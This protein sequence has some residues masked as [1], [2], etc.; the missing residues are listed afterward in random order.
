MELLFL[1][2]ITKFVS[3]IAPNLVNNS[4]TKIVPKIDPNLVNNSYIIL[5]NLTNQ[6]H[7]V[8]YKLPDLDC[9]ISSNRVIISLSA[10]ILLYIIMFMIRKTIIKPILK[11]IDFVLFFMFTILIPAIFGHLI[12]EN[13]SL[14]FST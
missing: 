14:L 9:S 7:D 2:S 1:N 4:I 10:T 8:I 11:I 5:Q 13:Y 3:K 6:F 12:W